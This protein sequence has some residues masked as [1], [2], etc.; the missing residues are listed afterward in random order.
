MLLSKLKEY[1]DE[2]EQLPPL[3]ASTPVAWIVALDSDGQPFAPQPISRID[4]STT[5]GKR[6]LD[7][8]APEY[9][10]PR[11]PRDNH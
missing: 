9:A 5:R 10:H 6:G 8:G 7:M 1:A 2:R 11:R 4:P 3:Y